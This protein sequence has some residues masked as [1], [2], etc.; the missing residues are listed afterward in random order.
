LAITSSVLMQTRLLSA[1]R[2]I[3]HASGNKSLISL[4]LARD[5]VT[6][7][8]PQ[9]FDVHALISQLCA[10]FPLDQDG[11]LCGLDRNSHYFG[12]RLG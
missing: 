6:D 1:T 9:L 4:P 3:S 5:S 12:L 10:F 2:H 11:L 7:G 8:I